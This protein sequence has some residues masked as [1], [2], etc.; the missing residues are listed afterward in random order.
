MS[1]PEMISPEWTFT[2]RPLRIDQSA[3][4]PAHG[5]IDQAPGCV[6]PAL[7]HR[8]ILS[9]SGSGIPRQAM[10]ITPPWATDCTAW[11]KSATR[12]VPP[13]WRTDG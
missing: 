3:G 6:R 7:Q 4:L 11:G 8:Q 5:D 9:T 10:R 13:A 12:Q 2:Q 1:V